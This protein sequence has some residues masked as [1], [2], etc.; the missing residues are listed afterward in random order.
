MKILYVNPS[1]LEAGLDAVIKAQP[2]ALASIA[3]MAPEHDAKLVDF[4]IHNYSDK[5]FTR[6]LN[7]YDVVAIS[8]MTPQIYSGFEVAQAA[9]KAGCTTILGGYH[10][11]LAPEYVAMHPAVDYAVRGEGEHSFKE[12]IDYL[13]EKNPKNLKNIKGIS[14]KNHK[15]DIIHNEE[16]PLEAIRVLEEYLSINKHAKAAKFLLRVIKRKM[17]LS[18]LAKTR[19]ESL[20]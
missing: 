17:E 9:K 2:L 15:G 19:L 14:Y 12:L 20:E 18:E 5:K 16:R 8:S 3:A 1:R 11:T 4:K 7:K 10:P 6:L 13:D